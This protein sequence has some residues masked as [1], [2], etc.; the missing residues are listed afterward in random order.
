MFNLYFYY[1][2]TSDTRARYKIKKA[3]ISIDLQVHHVAA[4]N[5]IY[6]LTS[7]SLANFHVVLGRWWCQFI[8]KSC[9]REA[10]LITVT[11]FYVVV[12]DP[13][14]KGEKAI[15]NI[16]FICR[17]REAHSTAFLGNHQVHADRRNN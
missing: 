8:Y 6:Y 4:C 16:I 9:C 5:W 11:K 10:E 17:S 12:Y 14:M 7:L 13:S 3:S 1:L 15:A 2:L